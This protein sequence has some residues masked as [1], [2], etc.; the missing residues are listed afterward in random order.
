MIMTLQ[1]AAVAAFAIVGA[2][3]LL[4]R[5]LRSMR[6]SDSGAPCPTCAS[7]AAACAKPTPPESAPNTAH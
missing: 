4:R 7:G 5:V 3:L 6:P 1:D 2:G